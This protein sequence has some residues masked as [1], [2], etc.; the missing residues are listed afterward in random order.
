MIHSMLVS[1]WMSPAETVSPDTPFRRAL[2]IMEQKAV[3]CLVVVDGGRLAG[4]LT[5]GD[6]RQAMPADKIT[7]MIWDVNNTWDTITVG[8]IMHD[9]VITIEPRASIAQAADIMLKHGISRLPVVDRHERLVG[10]LTSCDIY[11]MLVESRRQQNH[12]EAPAAAYSRF[13]PVGA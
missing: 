8:R 11:R 6:I 12:A 2:S 4:I 1:K 9:I 7:Q 5:L 13:S 10:I 3:R